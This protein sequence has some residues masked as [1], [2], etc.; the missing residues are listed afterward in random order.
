M[1]HNQTFVIIGI[2]N[3]AL[4]YVGALLLKF[5]K[6]GGCYAGASEVPLSVFILPVGRIFEAEEVRIVGA[7]LDDQIG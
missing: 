6:D 4:F 2:L 1:F 5:V 7:L 3:A